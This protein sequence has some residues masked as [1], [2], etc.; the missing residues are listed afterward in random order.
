MPYK[1]ILFYD[2]ETNGLDYYT[3]GIMQI[4]ILDKNGI[5]LLNE[6]VY[7]FDNRIDGTEIHNISEETLRENNAIETKELLVK[8]K[9]IIRDKYNRQIVYLMAYNNFGYDQNILENNFKVCNIKMPLNWYFIDIF[10]II[11][12]MFPNMQPNYKLKTIY[13]HLC[14]PINNLNFHSSLTDTTC[15][16]KIYNII[17]DS[18]YLIKK[19]TRPSIQ[20]KDYM[21]VSIYTL[22]GYSPFMKFELK[23]IYTIGDMFNLFKELN[24][25]KNQFEFYLKNTF[26]IYSNFFIRD[27][28]RQLHF[29][30]NLNGN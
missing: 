14:G 18:E 27:T 5:I 30:K 24:F 11:K 19:Y 12:E 1:N 6:Y 15:L 28:I 20:N 8:M 25:D 4:T 26:G 17:K 22:S 7:P 21:N 3:T 23:N 10:P 2:L 13:E 16:Y 9:N 29:I